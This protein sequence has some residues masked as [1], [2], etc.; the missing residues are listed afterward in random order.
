MSY[1][2][3]NQSKPKSILG[4]VKDI[5]QGSAKIAKNPAKVLIKTLGTV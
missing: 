4:K 3:N 2:K 5:Y 1:K